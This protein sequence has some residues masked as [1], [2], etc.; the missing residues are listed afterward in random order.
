MNQ[1]ESTPPD[2]SAETAHSRT[3]GLRLFASVMALA[4]GTAALVVAIVLVNGVL[5]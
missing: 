5:S 3:V 1:P 2:P 4:A